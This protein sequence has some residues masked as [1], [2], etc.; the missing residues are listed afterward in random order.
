MTK[1]YDQFVTAAH[2]GKTLKELLAAPIEAIKGVS[3]A[4]AVHLESAFGIKTVADLGASVYFERAASLVNADALNHDS[5]PPRDWADFFATAPIDYYIN[6]TSGRF[7][8]DF[9]PVYYRGRLDGSARVLVIGQDPSTNELLAHRIFVGRSG[10]R[11]QRF[12]RKL[13]ITRSYLMLNTFLFSV[14]EQFDTELRNISQ[15]PAIEQYRN[16]FL[17]RIADKNRIEAVVTFGVGARHAFK[18]W[19][20][21]A[22]FPVFHAMHPAAM[23]ANVL[24]NWNGLLPTMQQVVVPDDDGMVNAPLFGAAFT[25]EDLAPI[26]AFDLPFGVPGWLGRDGG[27]SRRNGNKEIVWQAP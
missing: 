22:S 11:V 20:S 8:L 14:F 1:S 19:P 21:G 18:R 2:R 26:P 9:G 15:E 4:D 25:P 17:D 23:E 7:R 24:A 16:A 6:H 12:L 13:G 3:A 10:Q 5:G 27:H